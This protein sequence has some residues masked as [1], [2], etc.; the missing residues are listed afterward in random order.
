MKYICEYYGHQ[1]ETSFDCEGSTE[2]DAAWNAAQE[3]FG[4]RY[5]LSGIDKT[6]AGWWQAM[7]KLRTA[8]R[9]NKNDLVGKPLKLVTKGR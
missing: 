3:L 9:D 8:G 2:Q 7:G 6:Q 5:S 1:T 4:E